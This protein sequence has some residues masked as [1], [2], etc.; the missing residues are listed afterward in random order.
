MDKY[1]LVKNQVEYYTKGGVKYFVFATQA[2]AAA[3]LGDDIHFM[4]LSPKEI[5]LYYDTLFS[6]YKNKVYFKSTRNTGRL[7][8][9]KISKIS[10]LPYTLSFKDFN[11]A[12]NIEKNFNTELEYNRGNYIECFL[13]DKS[14]E[15]AA[16]DM[17]P[18]DGYLN[19]NGEKCGIQLKTSIRTLKKDGSSNGFSSAEF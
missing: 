12:Y 11:N 6:A 8:F 14:I 15:K 13:F 3:H 4:V 17:S 16:T 7:F 9:S 18:I 19:I 1:E 10:R 2:P 5:L